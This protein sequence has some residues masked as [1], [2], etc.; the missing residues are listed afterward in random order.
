MSARLELRDLCPLKGTPVSLTLQAGEALALIGHNGSGKSEL[1]RAIAGTDP[2]N[3][4]QIVLDGED[5]SHISLEK[6]VARGIGWCPEGRRL[7]PALTVLETLDIAA[8]G[9]RKEREEAAQRM[10]ALFPPLTEKLHEHSWKLSGGQQQMLA[11]ARALIRSPRLV[12]LDEP[13]VG[14][15]PV[16]V[17]Q[18]SEALMQLKSEGSSLIISEPSPGAGFALADLYALLSRRQIVDTGRIVD[19]VETADRIGA[20]LTSGKL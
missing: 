18:I 15:A 5:I 4:G 11:L 20:S 17:E 13:F 10:L 7:F 2:T 14:L 12:L 6:R 9:T 3:S 19:R 1:I 8:T 16:I